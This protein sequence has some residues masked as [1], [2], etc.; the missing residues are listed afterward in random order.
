[1]SSIGNTN[2]FDLVTLAQVSPPGPS[3][4]CHLLGDDNLAGGDAQWDTLPRPRR[5]SVVEWTGSDLHTLTLPLMLDGF[6]V[7]PDGGDVSVEAACELLMSW[8][9][10][11]AGT[12]PPRPPTIVVGGP[13]R[14][15][16]YRPWWIVTGLEWG[17]QIRGGDGQRIQQAV[18]VALL[19]HLQ[20][21]VLLGP[22]AAARA[23]AGL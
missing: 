19:E 2:A 4:R 7:R 11:I 17:E 10:P 14:Q 23:R 15:P 21:Q 5:T 12:N 16:S 9:R 6:G 13:V 18:T 8:R 20:G 3:Q 1:M 22:A